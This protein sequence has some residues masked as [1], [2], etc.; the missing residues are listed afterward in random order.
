MPRNP[1]YK[2]AD[3][4]AE[5]ILRTIGQMLVEGDIKDPRLGLLSFTQVKL[6]DDLREAKVFF[7]MIGSAAQQREIEK[8]LNRGSGFIKREVAHRLGLRYVPEMHFYFD[9]S[10]ERAAR[11]N[12]LLAEAKRTQPPA[13]EENDENG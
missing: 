7:S 9:V 4:V 13:T 6:T 10:L 2:R 1:G 11:I 12:E 5:E 8:I 3:R